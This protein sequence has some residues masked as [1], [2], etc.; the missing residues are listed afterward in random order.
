[1]KKILIETLVKTKK[2]SNK[3]KKIKFDR[4]KLKNNEI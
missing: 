2:N 1:M 4:K 3:K